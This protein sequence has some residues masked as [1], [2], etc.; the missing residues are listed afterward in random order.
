MFLIPRGSLLLYFAHELIQVP[1]PISDHIRS[2]T[3]KHMLDPVETIENAAQ[4]AFTKILQQMEEDLLA[5]LEDQ[6]T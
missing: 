1:I 3:E 4:S 6:L 5:T 2:V